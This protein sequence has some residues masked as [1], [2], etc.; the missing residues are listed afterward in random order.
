MLMKIGGLGGGGS[1]VPGG[2]VSPSFTDPN[3]ENPY[4][5]IDP[6]DLS[7][8]TDTA[9]A[10]SQI[11]DKSGHGLYAIDSPSP[12]L[13][14]VDTIN[15]LNALTFAGNGLR[16]SGVALGFVDIFLVFNTSDIKYTPLLYGAA[17]YVMLLESGSGSSLV[18]K[19]AGSPSYYKNGVLQTATT[20]GDLHAAFYNQDVVALIRNADLSLWSYLNIY[21]HSS[22]GAEMDG[23]MGELIIIP[24]GKPD[25]A[26]NNIGHYLE[27]WGITWT[28]I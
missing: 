27:R 7:T 16:I 4:I 18:S 15:S 21:N 26:I 6:S 23:L 5:W 10:V 19:N 9:N 1:A 11:N 22:T 25:A 3:D 20:R 2:I 8:I 13:T 17:E 12:P 24:A 14:G 28:D